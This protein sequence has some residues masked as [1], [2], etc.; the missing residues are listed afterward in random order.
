MSVIERLLTVEEVAQIVG[1]KPSTV[2]TWVHDRSI[3]FIKFGPGK[4]SPLRFNPESIQRWYEEKESHPGDDPGVLDKVKS[5][6]IR[7][8]SKRTVEKFDQLL[9]KSIP[10]A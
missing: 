9:E 4:K 6:T 2:K 1:V 8:A 10:G 3:P 5:G 7:K